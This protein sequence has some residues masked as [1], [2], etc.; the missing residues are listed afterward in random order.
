MKV[1]IF[2][3]HE[4]MQIKIANV[5]PPGWLKCNIEKAKCGEDVQPMTFPTFLWVHNLLQ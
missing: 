2:I 3:C 4:E 5:I 1:A